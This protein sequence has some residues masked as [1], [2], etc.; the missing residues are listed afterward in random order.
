MI[1]STLTILTLIA[2]CSA[3]NIMNKTSLTAK[4]TPYYIS[5]TIDDKVTS[6]SVNGADQP[7]SNL[8]NI[9]SHINLSVYNYHFKAGDEVVVC[10]HNN[11]PYTL[12]NPGCF[13]AEIAY[14]DNGF[15]NYSYTDSNW[16]CGNGPAYSYGPSKP[17]EGV[18]FFG[19]K[20]N[21]IWS[22]T[23]SDLDTC[24]RIKLPSTHPAPTPAPT[25]TPTPAPEPQPSDC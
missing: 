24:C 14:D 1:K 9:S 16:W 12:T 18:S 2:F 23:L 11:S 5:M 21:W 3:V 13:I 20:G 7:I 22:A 17:V 4:Q 19:S 10:G 8:P 25:P 15:I 6:L